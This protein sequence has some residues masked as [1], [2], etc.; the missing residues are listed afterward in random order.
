MHKASAVLTAG[1]NF[2]LLGGRATMLQSSKPVVAVCAV[3][4]GCGK[5]Q[6]TRRVCEILK[7]LGFKVAAV[8]HPMPYGNL[9]KQACQRFAALEDLKKQRCTIEEMEEY[10]PHIARGQVVYAGVDYAM[11]LRE[12][13]KEADVIVWDGGNNDMPF[14]L[15]DI[16]ITVADPHRAGHEISYYPGESNLLG[17][18]VV[19]I[20]K[21]DTADGDAVDEVRANIRLCNPDA[22][23][24][25]AA[26]PIAVEEPS[27]I[28]NKRVL[29]IE[30]GPTATHGEMEFG[31]GMVAAQK[32]GAAEAVD[33]RPYLKGSL[34]ETFEQYPEIGALLPAMGY[35]GKQVKDLEAT[36]AATDCDSVIIG[37]PID[38][39]RVIKIKQPSTRVLYDLQEL[40]HPTLQEI[41]ENAFSARKKGGK[42]S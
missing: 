38:L 31:A 32:F 41:L 33:P 11:I 27:V 9:A 40:G 16:Y 7:G 30:D 19:V 4:T 26:S 13:E 25:V 1:A 12:A 35:G 6:T 8:R 42:K 3:R 18:D 14:Y 2:S 22:I 24:V 39:R 36:I 10:E 34:K 15:A 23:V 20:N 5:S 21:I 28:S 29:V 37:T 17:A